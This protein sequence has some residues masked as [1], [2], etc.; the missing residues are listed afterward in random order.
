M[1]YK[2]YHAIEPTFGFGDQPEFPG[3]Y[4]MVAVVD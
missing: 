1:Q 4:Q 3:D 2:V